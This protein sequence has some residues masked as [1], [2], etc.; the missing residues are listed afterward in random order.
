MK[1]GRDNNGGG[2][3]YGFVTTGQ[4]WHMLAYDGG[5][6]RIARNLVAAF[7]GM[8]EDKDQ[9][10]DCS[11]LVDCL[12]VALSNDGIVKDVVVG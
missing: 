11:V 2:V 7:L 8:G 9:G 5:V 4:I 1:D 6:F 10:M 12:V 3:V